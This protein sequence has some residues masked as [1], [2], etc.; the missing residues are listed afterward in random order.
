M[1]LPGAV[2]RARAWGSAFAR[3]RAI[4]HACVARHEAS[5]IPSA[6]PCGS[7]IPHTAIRCFSADV[8]GDAVKDALAASLS[9]PRSILLAADALQSEFDE[10]VQRHV[11]L[12]GESSFSEALGAY[13][14]LRQRH[15]PLTERE[16]L[17]LL[18]KSNQAG[19]FDDTVHL[20]EAF[21]AAEAA[22]TAAAASRRPEHAWQFVSFHRQ[23]MVRF[24]LWALLAAG[25]PKEMLPLYRQHVHNKPNR[26]AVYES[27][28]FNFLLRFECM[29]RF[30]GQSE[31]EMK[32][33]AEDVLQ[34]MEKR[35]YHTSY[36][37]AHALFRFVLYHPE[38]FVT[39]GEEVPTSPSSKGKVITDALFW[40]LDTFPIALARDPKRMSLAVSASAAAG[41]HDVV[42]ALLKDAEAQ[43]IKIDEASFGHALMSAT[44][45]NKRNEITELYGRTERRN[46]LF[47]T[48]NEETSI[49][50]YL[51]LFA[52]YDGNFAQIIDMLHEMQFYANQASNKTVEE[53]FRSI[54]QF[55]AGIRLTEPDNVHRLADCPTIVQ[56]MDKFPSVIPRTVHT[57]SV[58]IVQSL[59]GG[60]IADALALLRTTV[61]S[62]TVVVRPE[63]FAQVMYPIMAGV[64][65]TKGEA[66][67]VEVERLFDSQHKGGRAMLN[68]QIVNLCESGDDLATL[69]VCL[70]RWQ[71][72]G[73]DRMS[74]VV[75]NRV[76]NVISKQRQQLRHEDEAQ[77][78]KYFVHD[79]ELSFRGILAK[80]PSIVPAQ[81][82]WTVGAA[83]IRSATSELYDDVQLLLMGATKQ[84]LKL[85]KAAY[86][87]GLETLE[88]LEA[89]DDVL[90]CGEWLEA[91]DLLAPLGEA[92]P[93]TIEIVETARS[94]T[95]ARSS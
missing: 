81:A 47:A 29:G 23:Q 25:R 45:Q 4:A 41:Y 69:L 95:E 91:Q 10:S 53:L 18:F 17:S 11:L 30:A 26:H 93:R 79:V 34:E 92:Y 66:S 67:L 78:V 68:A 6:A 60:D 82:A 21:V 88:K 19:A 64:T 20:F 58:G 51:L 33:R 12:H 44:T 5:V 16:Y 1:A 89:W 8:G 24:V 77:G 62:T 55:R 48:K 73:Y 90:E 75:L 49:S 35:R 54:A 9:T 80:Y 22:Q 46:G 76:F 61:W 31:A 39:A 94:K 71:A 36:S 2:C 15:L 3:S 57:T 72:H 65:E 43:D 85:E 42:V 50:N 84:G 83:I 59:K 14:A 13:E 32:Q 63:I 87:V 7:L 27:D 38:L 40:Y 52:V 28:P 86:K 74:K 70:N 37:S 56:L